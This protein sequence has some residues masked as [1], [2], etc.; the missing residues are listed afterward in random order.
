MP[1]APP[2]PS[3]TAPP[4]GEP[5]RPPQTEPPGPP[6]KL[7]IAPA[8]VIAGL[9]VGTILVEVVYAAAGTNLSNPSPAASIGG[10][11]VFDLAFV[12]AAIYFAW[13][14]ARPSPADFGYVRPRLKRATI[15][16]VAAAAFYYFATFAYGELFK[17]HGSDKLPNE[18]GVTKSTAALV[19]A[20]VFVCVLAPIFEEFFFRGFFF[21]VL[22]RW[23]INVAG[24]QLGPW[25]AA[26]FT[27]ALFGIAHAGSASSVYLIPLGLLG[28][29]L[30][31]VRWWTGSLYP[32]MVIH[33]VNNC[34]ALGVNQEHWNA[35]EIL[36][37]MAGSLFV[38]GVVTGPLSRDRPSP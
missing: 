3:A 8:A 36:G 1:S 28:F 14:Q 26:L 33:S 27:A 21:G 19:A 32:G 37:L 2:P 23:R 7:W 18:L 10:D 15:V 34:L 31:L 9:L 4:F 6:W 22:A 16:T 20:T 24:R 25:V 29:V 5:P 38:I 30:C 12:A 17:I 13:T 11:L 35:G